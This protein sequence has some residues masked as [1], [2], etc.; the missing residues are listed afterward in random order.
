MKTGG[1]GEFTKLAKCLLS[2]GGRRGVCRPIN[3][4]PKNRR[5]V[6]AR[7]LLRSC[8]PSLLLHKQGNLEQLLQDHVHS[9]F[10]YLCKWKL[11]NPS[12]QP[13]HGKKTKKVFSCVQTEFNEFSFIFITCCAVSGCYCEQSGSIFCIPSHQVFMDIDEIPP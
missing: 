6:E 2:Q 10:E 12:G 7:S 11:H 13:V 3:F 5:I 9:A 8:G 1:T 4:T